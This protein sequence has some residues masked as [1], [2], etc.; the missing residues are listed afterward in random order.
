MAKALGEDRHKIMAVILYDEFHYT[1]GA[2]AQ[3]MGVAPNTI[4]TWISFGRLLIQNQ[5]LQK[6]V[7]ELR[8]SLSTIGYNPVKQLNASEIL[9]IID[10]N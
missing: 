3:L 6:E 8:N 10:I 4:S 5:N 2:I 1:Q 7:Q 9:P